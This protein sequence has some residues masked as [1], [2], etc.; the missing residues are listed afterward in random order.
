MINEDGAFIGTVKNGNNKGSARE[1]DRGEGE[2]TQLSA[3]KSASNSETA[4]EAFV[5]KN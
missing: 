1:E 3:A 5:T 4:P 2:A